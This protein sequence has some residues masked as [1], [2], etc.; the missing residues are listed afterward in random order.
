DA[1]REP[2]HAGVLSCKES[3]AELRMELEHAADDHRDQRLL[4]L[5]PMAGHVAVEAVLT[6][7]LDH[8][9][10]EGAHTLVESPG[11][12]ELFVQAVEGLPV[13]RAPV[14]TV[15]DS[16]PTGA[17]YGAELPHA[18]HP[19]LTRQEHVGHGHHR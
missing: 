2:G 1:G 16:R 12:V 11:H 14:A 15:A 6:V 9:G 3:D 4:H 17:P 7:E 10:V 13:V 8:V 5:D 18:P 19:V